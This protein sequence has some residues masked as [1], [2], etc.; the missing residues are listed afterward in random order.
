MSKIKLV[1]GPRS[2]FDKQ[3]NMPDLMALETYVTFFDQTNH[4]LIEAANEDK[5]REKLLG[6]TLYGTSE[7]F[8]AITQSGIETLSES[9]RLAVK[10]AENIILQNPPRVVAHQ[11]RVSYPDQTGRYCKINL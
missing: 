6:K 9:L 1:I 11:L 8:A 2:F 4:N 3:I 5:F 7:S 10:F